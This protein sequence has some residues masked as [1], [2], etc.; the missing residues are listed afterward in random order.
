MKIGAS[1]LA[2]IEYNLEKTLEFIEDLGLDY[3]E[4]VHQFPCENIDAE[5]LENFNLKYSIHA[6]FIDVNI[7]SV[8]TESRLNSIQQIKSSID[9]ANKIDA[10]SVV[11]HPGLATFLPNKYFR[12]E[13]IGFAEQSMIE[14]GAYGDELG[15]M[16]TFENM[17]SFEAMLYDNMEELNEFLS[18]NGLYM[19]LDIG[20]ANHSGYGADEMYFD[21]IKHIHI[22]DNFGDD[23]AHL[24][25]G[26]G[27]IDL[28]HI[29]NTLEKNNY[30]GIYIIEV[31][32]YDSIKKSYEY[33]KKNF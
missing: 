7:A 16:T 9:L 15:V 19:A 4:L 23:D 30:D 8:Q 17:P 31:N 29:V 5:V 32:D 20:H 28:N 25:L 3:A 22:H 33:M 13:V 21:S 27:S 14:L 24:T 2:G 12:K 26:E 11:I 10:D 6:P 18:S 1:T